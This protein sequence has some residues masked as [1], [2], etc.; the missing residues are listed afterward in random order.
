MKKTSKKAL[1]LLL[2]GVL[3]SLSAGLYALTIT[4]TQVTNN[5]ANDVSPQINGD[6]VVWRGYADGD[7]EIYLYRISSGTTTQVT[8]NTASDDYPQINGDYVVWRGYADGDSEIYLYQ[9]SSGTTTQVTNNTA[10]DASPQIDGDYV[11][12]YGYTDG[13]SEI[14][15]YRIS[16][17]TTT[18][19]STNTAADTSPQING[20]Y[21][22]WHG[23]ANGDHEIY[24]AEI[25]NTDDSADDPT[26]DPDELP[27]TG[28]A[29]GRRASLP[30]QP[31]GKAY[32]GMGMTLEI[33]ALEMAMPIVGVPQ[34]ANSWD[35]TWLGDNAGYLE[36]S[37]FP[38][39][40][41]NT[42]LTG[43]V[44]DAF[45]QPGPF[46]QL[47]TLQ[48]GDTLQIHA[49]GQ[50]YTYE[51]RESRLVTRRNV[52]AVFAPEDYDWITLVTCELYNPFT[53]EY[54]SRRMVRAVLVSVE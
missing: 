44:W 27:A 22:V 15:L 38:T 37:A 28:F 49:W 4:T 19:V 45:N 53:G 7:N 1:V 10:N 33:P 40:A 12:W 46:A 2:A 8:N 13:D 32:A 54:I 11:V 14:Y 25:L 9:I 29:Q 39:W 18:Q 41:G 48:Y 16:S 24:L 47:K 6:Y 50:T 21:M 17:S 30:V 42:V 3:L 43:H 36:G 51:V 52:E 23:N 26:D 34:S 20:D 31:A 5:T 35:V